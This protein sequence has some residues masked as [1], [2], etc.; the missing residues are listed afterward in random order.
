MIVLDEQLLQ[1]DLRAKIARW[2]RGAVIGIT[3][4]RPGTHILDEAIPALLRS[5][6]QPTFATINVTDFWR[7]WTPDRKFCVACLDLPSRRID[8][9]P[10]L[11][12]RL[13]A[14]APFHTR[15]GRLGKIARVRGRQVQYYTV[16]SWAIRVT[17]LA[18]RQ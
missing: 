6:R 5:V 4:L 9:I 11:L 8:E 13:L 14:T 15:R 1:A 2:Y 17:G 18:G 7:Q 12:R 10:G 3:E 16:D